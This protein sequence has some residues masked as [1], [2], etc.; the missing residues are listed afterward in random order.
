MKITES[1]M[2]WLVALMAQVAEANADDRHSDYGRHRVPMFGAQ[3]EVLTEE[4][5]SL[6]NETPKTNHQ[7][8]Q[9]R[10]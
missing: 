2:R 3:A 4:F 10:D 8:I 1:Q 6:D 9:Q 7:S 5:N